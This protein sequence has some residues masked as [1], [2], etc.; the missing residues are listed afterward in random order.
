MRG[1]AR[2]ASNMLTTNKDF[3]ASRRRFFRGGSNAEAVPRPPWAADE[4]RFPELCTR[5]DLCIDGCPENILRRGSGGFP[6]L[7]FRKGGCTLCGACLEAC[8]PG[9]LSITVHPPLPWTMTV[10]DQCLSAQGITCRACG[11]E[12]EQHAI[13]FRLMVGGRAEVTVVAEACNGC[14]ACIRFCPADAIR[15]ESGSRSSEVV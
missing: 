6:E 2:P 9:A 5:C 1:I 4:A 7:D 3:D 14:G 15:V 11:D 10:S 12:C 13:R 8:E